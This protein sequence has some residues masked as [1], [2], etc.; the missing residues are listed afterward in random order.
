[1]I[2]CIFLTFTEVISLLIIPFHI[3]ICNLE[4]LIVCLFMWRREDTI[5]SL[6]WKV[7][8]FSSLRKMLKKQKFR[9]SF[10]RIIYD[11]FSQNLFSAKTWPSNSEL[12]SHVVFPRFL[13]SLS[14]RIR[15]NGLNACSTQLKWNSR[16]KY[17]ERV[18]KSWKVE[19][20]RERN[21]EIRWRCNF[22]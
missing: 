4:K 9:I 19:K 5:F 21:C 11:V 12:F 14:K 17:R 15:N 3:S 16:K 2:E 20:E 18:Y 8:P 6:I 1:M 22:V 7:F 13:F 10:Q